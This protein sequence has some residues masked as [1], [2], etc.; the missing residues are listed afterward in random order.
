[1][2]LRDDLAEDSRRD[3]DYG[4]YS[5]Q[6]DRLPEPLSQPEHRT[7]LQLRRE[8]EARLVRH[9]AMLREDVLHPRRRERKRTLNSSSS[10]SEAR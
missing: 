9:E 10:S 3:A 5:F 1:M 2:P 8:A 6:P 7:S 4:L